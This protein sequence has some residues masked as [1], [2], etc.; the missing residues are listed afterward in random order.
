MIIRPTLKLFFHGSHENIHCLDVLQPVAVARL[1]AELQSCPRRYG[2]WQMKQVL[3][4]DQEIAV[5][6]SESKA[7][8]ID[9]TKM[10]QAQ[11][12]LPTNLFFFLPAFGQGH[13]PIEVFAFKEI[14]FFTLALQY[15]IKFTVR[16][17]YGIE[18]INVLNFPHE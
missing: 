3:S 11:S 8:R 16:L 2:G 13:F 12:G 4:V 18:Q 5:L 17:C 10:V 14:E 9:K 1:C 6:I 7:S 15:A